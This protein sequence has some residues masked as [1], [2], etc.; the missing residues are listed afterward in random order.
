MQILGLWFTDAKGLVLVH[1][2]FVALKLWILNFLTLVPILDSA[3]GIFV[4]L[5]T[6]LSISDGLID[7][8]MHLIDRF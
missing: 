7:Q 5:M 6:H 4:I 8:L 1:D 3:S 2:I